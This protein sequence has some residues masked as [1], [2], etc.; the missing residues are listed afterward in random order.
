MAQWLLV[1][2]QRFL[3]LT[4]ISWQQTLNSASLGNKYLLVA[5]AFSG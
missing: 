4:Q 2:Q 1:V 3:W 5:A